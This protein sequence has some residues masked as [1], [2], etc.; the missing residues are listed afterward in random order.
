MNETQLTTGQRC[1]SIKIV[2]QRRRTYPLRQPTLSLS[3]AAPLL[4]TQYSVCSY[5]KLQQRKRKIGISQNQPNK[6][7]FVNFVFEHTHTE[8]VDR[9]D[10]LRTECKR[11]YFTLLV[12][13]CVCVLQKN[14][15]VSYLIFTVRYIS[16][17][18][19]QAEFG[20]KKVEPKGTAFKRLPFD[21]CSL[22]LQ[23]FNDPVCNA[24]GIVYDI[25]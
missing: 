2:A 16:A 18:E 5:R 6:S 4:A 10:N 7:T 9:K 19:W 15:I 24:K 17:A 23:P 14:I 22:S 3:A 20:G 13:V 8:W 12:C 1:R 25:L 11:L 21:C